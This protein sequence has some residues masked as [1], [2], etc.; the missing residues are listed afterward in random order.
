MKFED[1]VCVLQMILL[2]KIYR[3]RYWGSTAKT[4]SLL[5]IKQ[6]LSNSKVTRGCAPLTDNRISADCVQISL[7]PSI[8]YIPLRVYHTGGFNAM[9]Y[10]ITIGCISVWHISG[11]QWLKL[12][13]YH[14]D[15]GFS[16]VEVRQSVTKRKQHGPYHRRAMRRSG[17]EISFLASTVWCNE[18]H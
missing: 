10:Q 3:C 6:T 13:C 11:N 12:Y 8:P 17:E 2:T 1:F 18:S 16:S 5:G 14:R 4:I 9:Y 7:V 15:I